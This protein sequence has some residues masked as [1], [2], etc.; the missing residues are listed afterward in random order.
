MTSLRKAINDHCRQCIYD[1]LA[2]GT[3]K[4]QVTLCSVYSCALYDVRPQTTSTI[5]VSVLSYYGVNLAEYQG[6]NRL[7]EGQSEPNSQGESK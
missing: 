6:I 4:Q 1:N 2:A 5:P 7:F 3:W